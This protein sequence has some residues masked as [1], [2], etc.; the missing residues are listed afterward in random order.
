[1]DEKTDQEATVEEKQMQPSILIVG[2][3]YVS[4]PVNIA[5][6]DGSGLMM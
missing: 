2:E 6:L 4:M 5:N 1:M 3:H